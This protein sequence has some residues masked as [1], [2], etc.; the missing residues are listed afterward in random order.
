ML[1]SEIR[2]D[3]ILDIGGDADDTE[4]Q[5][6]VLAW[7]KSAL[8]RFP[9][10]CRGRLL[11]T[12]KSGTLSAAAT[13]M[14]LPT[15]TRQIFQVYYLTSDN[16]RIEITMPGL[17]FFNEQYRGN[18]TGVP[19]YCIVRGNTVEF[20]RKNDSARTIYFEAQGE[21]S[22]VSSS[23]TWS[24]SEDESEILKDGVKFYYYSYK[25]DEEQKAEYKSLF[26]AGLDDIDAQYVRE[27]IPDHVEET[28]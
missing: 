2:D 15:G 11:R 24:W 22:S 13:T 21:I 12:T 27:E 6:K 16:K 20:N 23:D 25:E 5:T 14:T 9:R 10:W 3:I 18:D 1:I 8:R 17:K 4:L 28:L 7:I 26:K 19:E